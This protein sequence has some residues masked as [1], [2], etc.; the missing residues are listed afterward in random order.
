MRLHVKTVKRM[1]I[2]VLSAFTVLM[3]VLSCLNFQAF[4]AEPE[5]DGY[6][7][8]N[9]II[10]YDESTTRK[11]QNAVLDENNLEKVETISNTDNAVLAQTD[12]NTSVD[13]AIREVEKDDN[14]V[15]AQKNYR[16][17][18]LETTN[19]PYVS[20]QVHLSNTMVSSSSDSAWNY[21][22]GQGVNIAILDSGLD[23]SL[24]D[25]KNHL[26]GTY[27]ATN[28]TADVSETEEELSHSRGHGTH[29]TGI[30]AAIGNNSV[31]GAGVAYNA[32]IYFAKVFCDDEEGYGTY[33]SDIVKAYDWAISKKCRIINMSLG[34]ES[35]DEYDRILSDK[36]S[37]AYTKTENSVL[38]VCA[39][40]N[41]GTTNKTYP[42]DYPDSYSVTA[43]NYNTETPTYWAGSDHNQYKDIAAPGTRILS[44]DYGN[45]STLVMKSGTSMAAPF[46]SGTAAL[47][48]SVNP[49]LSA[50]QITDIINR[51]SQD[52]TSTE[53]QDGYGHGLIDPYMAVRSCTYMV[54]GLK[55][56]Y[57]PLANGKMTF[58]V[59]GYSGG[60]NLNFSILDSEG[61]T[62]KSLGGGSFQSEEKKTFSW[63]FTNEEGKI[64]PSGKY[65]VKGVIEGSA[66][67][68]INYSKTVTVNIADK[69]VMTGY[70]VT[71]KTERNDFNA[72]KIKYVLNNKTLMNTSVLDSEGNEIRK[73]SANRDGKV[74]ETWDLKNSEGKLVSAG[75]YTVKTTGYNI[76]GKEYSVSSEK[77]VKITVPGKIQIPSYANSKKKVRAT[78]EKAVI[79]FR[80]S[81][82]A[83]V[84]IKIYDK[85]GKT[86]RTLVN[87]KVLRKGLHTAKW[88]EKNNS[89]KIVKPGVYTIR[90]TFKNSVG[91][92]KKSGKVSL[93]KKKVK[94]KVYGPKSSYKLKGTD[95]PGIKVKTNQA[96]KIKVTVVNSSGKTVAT[97]MKA[98]R[99]PKGTY[100]FKWNKK[101]A[102]KGNYRFRVKIY[103]ENGKRTY[104]GSSFRLK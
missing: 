31:C 93:V 101:S 52:V 85:K 18:L 82:D 95:Y 67:D 47:M 8:E 21:S 68:K 48:L 32:N 62:V 40:G 1:T 42:S 7:S 75:T 17:K 44:L 6:S 78:G 94:A 79:K 72:V 37:A 58:N 26:K 2:K 46:V 74:T 3:L 89:G 12:E 35:Y 104:T 103:N 43:V 53:E 5:T 10:V 73:F 4:A 60:L 45:D 15:Y 51:T 57:S 102:K 38:T 81:E 54:T 77:T 91:S 22:T 20:N 61:N 59:T 9:I 65:T 87:G 98:T 29:V 88:N 27:N 69:P 84:T 70:S 11:E 13:E 28:G 96:L 97:V 64:V 63:D 56:S 14:V 99:K 34:G 83:R 55:S 41:D 39:G 16:Y 23:T 50:K 100:K 25:I 24:T 71:S 86:V 33:T 49:N 66:N 19:D 30:A 76:W 92:V 90:T 36:V 80:Q